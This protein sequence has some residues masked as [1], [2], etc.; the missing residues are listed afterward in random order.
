MQAPTTRERQPDQRT[1]VKVLLDQKGQTFTQ[2]AGIPIEENTPGVLFQHLCMSL[3]L[4]AR[5]SAGNALEA[6][7]ALIEAGFTTP[8]K[9]ASASWQ[10]RVDVITWHGYKRYDERTSTMLGT[11]ASLVLEK[12]DG[13]LRQ[14]RQAAGREVK[15]EHALLQ[16]FSGIGPIGADIFLREVQLVWD[17]VFP[18]ADRKVLQAASRLGLPDDAKDLSTMVARRDFARLTAAL[19]RTALDKQYDEISQTSRGVR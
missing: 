4:S 13:D 2:A 6:T 7:R 5:I 18:Y 12:Y 8:H 17:E 19:I 15:R 14:L 1:L 9:M 16:E 10:Q 3:L 11:T